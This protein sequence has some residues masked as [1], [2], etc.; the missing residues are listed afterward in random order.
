MYHDGIGVERDYTEALKW[1]TKAA[2]WGYVSA[3]Y[4]LAGMYL[5][6][7]G[8]VQDYGKAEKW[9]RKRQNREVL[10]RRRSWG[11][12]IVTEPV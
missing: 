8:V 12:C 11:I 1:Y 10:K 2:W 6:A 4:N 3:Q 5:E 7:R 9:Y